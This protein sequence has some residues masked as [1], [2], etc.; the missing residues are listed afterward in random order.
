VKIYV[1]HNFNHTP[2]AESIKTLCER[3]KKAIHIMAGKLKKSPE[4]LG[5]RKE[6]RPDVERGPGFLKQLLPKPGEKAE[7]LVSL[8]NS[9]RKHAVDLAIGHNPYTTFI[10]YVRLIPVP[11]L[12]KFLEPMDSQK[13]DKE[14]YEIKAIAELLD[15]KAYSLI[16]NQEERLSPEIYNKLYLFRAAFGWRCCIPPSSQAL[17]ALHPIVFQ[18]THS[19]QI[20]RAWSSKRRG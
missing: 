10:Y 17:Q 20:R 13:K 11:F 3:L 18:L 12:K 7:K 8:I 16:D 4:E 5:L 15:L 6:Y 1:G 2:I 19:S 14:T 9:F